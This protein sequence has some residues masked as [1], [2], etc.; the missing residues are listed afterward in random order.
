MASLVH[1]EHIGADAHDPTDIALEFA[2]RKSDAAGARQRSA[3]RAVGAARVLARR[4][5]NAQVLGTRLPI[6]VTGAP[7]LFIT[8]SLY[9]HGAGCKTQH[10]PVSARPPG[11]RG[12]GG[13]LFL[14]EGGAS[15]SAGGARVAGTAW[16][17]RGSPPRR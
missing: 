17:L 15:L 11:E 14:A 6:H 12:Q 10:R 1:H 8:L 7:A 3:A 2:V 4:A 9:L 5:Q 13:A 16:R